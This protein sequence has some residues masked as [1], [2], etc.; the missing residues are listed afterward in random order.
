M[1]HKDNCSEGMRVITALEQ[2]RR[3]NVTLTREKKRNAR[4]TYSDQFRE[5]EEAEVAI[6]GD[7]TDL[8]AWERL[9]DAQAA[10]EELRLAKLEMTRILPRPYEL[11]SVIDVVEIFWSSIKI[12]RGGLA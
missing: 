12:A 2:I 6:Q 8:S 9:N 11:E 7:W 5:I 10:S 3:V 4:A 1:G